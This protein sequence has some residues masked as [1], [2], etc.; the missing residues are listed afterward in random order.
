MATS[1]HVNA[2]YDGSAGATKDDEDEIGSL[3]EA[4][5]SWLTNICEASLTPNFEIGSLAFFRS[6]SHQA[7]IEHL[8]TT[9]DMLDYSHIED[10][11]VHTLS[12]SM[13]LPKQSIWNFR[14]MSPPYPTPNPEAPVGWKRHGHRSR[15][16]R[17]M[18]S[19]DW[20]RRI[21][22]ARMMQA[23]H[24]LWR[25]ISED[26]CRQGSGPSLMSGNTVIDERNFSLM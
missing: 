18:L 24:T 15:T 1:R 21:E 20:S 13:F 25:T 14:R 7:L 11:P 22:L 8:D 6:P 9:D 10:T 16:E 5:T 2:Q 26:F 4:F 23:Q 12:A 3:A 19:K 17:R